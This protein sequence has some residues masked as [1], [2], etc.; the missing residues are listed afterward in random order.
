MK[1]PCRCRL[2]RLIASDDHEAEAY[3]RWPFYVLAGTAVAA[4]LGAVWLSFGSGR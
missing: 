3:P 4:W 1:A 2:C